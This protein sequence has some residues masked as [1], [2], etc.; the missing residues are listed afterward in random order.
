MKGITKNAGRAL[1]EA[2]EFEHT[3]EGECVR[4]VGSVHGGE[5]EI[6]RPCSDD[7]VFKFD[8]RPV[9]VVGPETA[10][11][12]GGQVLDYTD[13]QFSMIAGGLAAAVEY[14]QTSEFAHA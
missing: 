3:Q 2:L 10:N 5:F 9:L 8:G 7:R 6:D 11:V 13:E 14:G 12:C 1:R 4:F